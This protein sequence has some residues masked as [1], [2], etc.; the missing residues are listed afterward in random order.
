MTSVKVLETSSTSFA[1][2]FNHDK[3]C[4][5]VCSLSTECIMQVT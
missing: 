3:V 1:D 4:N 5:L 2:Q